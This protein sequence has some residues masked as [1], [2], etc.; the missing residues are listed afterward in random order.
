M[1]TF[2]LFDAP[3]R[4]PSHFVGFA[5]NRIDRQSENRRDDCVVEALDEIAAN[6]VRETAGR[7]FELAFA[8]H[9]HELHTE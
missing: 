1:T 9:E 3:E 4:E 8:E 7:P 2:S 5:G 6:R